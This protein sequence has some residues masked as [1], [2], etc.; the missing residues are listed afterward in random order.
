MVKKW[1]NIRPSQVVRRINLITMFKKKTPRAKWKNMRF[2]VQ[3]WHRSTRGRKRERDGNSEQNKTLFL[4]D[5]M[6]FSLLREAF[7]ELKTI[8]FRYLKN[9]IQSDKKYYKFT[10]VNAHL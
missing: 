3:S 5:L 6:M 7:I 10:I 9:V 4:D 2:G 8:V 1:V